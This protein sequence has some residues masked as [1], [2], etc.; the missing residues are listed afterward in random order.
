MFP[1]L[2]AAYPPPFDPDTTGTR[3]PHGPGPTWR[4]Y[5]VSQY[6]KERALSYKDARRVLAGPKGRKVAGLPMWD[7]RIS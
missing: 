6:A 3:L 7:V 1:V 4:R 5:T 2:P